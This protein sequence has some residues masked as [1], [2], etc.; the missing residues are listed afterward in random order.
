[1]SAAIIRENADVEYSAVG[2]CGQT[3][4]TAVGA[5]NDENVAWDVTKKAWRSW[6]TERLG[7]QR[8]VIRTAKKQCFPREKKMAWASIVAQGT[9]IVTC[10]QIGGDPK[11][12]WFC[13][14]DATPCTA[15]T[16][17]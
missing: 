3:T 5:D 12:K 16:T 8:T 10:G 14:L 6:V 7:E 4:F 1:L 11:G 9:K 13:H 17:P 15:P 2:T